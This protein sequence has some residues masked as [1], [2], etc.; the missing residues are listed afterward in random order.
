M[1]IFA[2]ALAAI[3]ISPF[4]LSPA[5]QAVK[6]K[7]PSTRA[8]DKSPYCAPP[9]MFVVRPNKAKP[10]SAEEPKEELPQPSIRLGGCRGGAQNMPFVNTLAYDDGHQFY[11]GGVNSSAGIWES[12]LMQA[13]WQIWYEECLSKDSK[14]PIKLGSYVVDSQWSRSKEKSGASWHVTDDPQVPV[15]E[16]NKDCMIWTPCE[17]NP[18]IYVK[19]KIDFL[20]RISRNGLVDTKLTDSNL[21]P[22]RTQ[23]LLNSFRIC[24]GH[25][26]FCLPPGYKKDSIELKVGLD[27][28]REIGPFFRPGAKKAKL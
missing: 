20:L 10:S 11:E 1:R 18:Y 6:K 7:Q 16:A 23:A 25:P 21:P 19:G 4:G 2:L 13:V 8:I 27:A 14:T 3:L 12:A 5:A 15:P 9:P 22:D 26:A 28:C 17:N 24:K